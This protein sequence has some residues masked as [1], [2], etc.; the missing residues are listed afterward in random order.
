VPEQDDKECHVAI[1]HECGINA[2]VCWKGLGL[3][4]DLDLGLGVW[5]WSAAVLGR[6]SLRFT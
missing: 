6:T 3:D 2:N 5:G 4:L 1:G